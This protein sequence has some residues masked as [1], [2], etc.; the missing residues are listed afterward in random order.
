MQKKRIPQPER[1]RKI[2]GS[3]A[4]IEHRF[5]RAGFWNKLSQ[6]EL[7]LYFF[8]ILVADRAGLS[9]YGDEKIC[10]YC[11]LSPE[12]LLMARKGLI[13]KDLI[14]FDRRMFQVLSLPSQPSLPSGHD[15]QPRDLTPARD[16]LAALES[17][18]MSMQGRKNHG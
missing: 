8:L 4:F 3:F 18:R 9:F 11:G 5:L 7:I 1:V 2:N 17:L 6:Q 14:A 16:A 12:E 15:L 13:Q 10:R